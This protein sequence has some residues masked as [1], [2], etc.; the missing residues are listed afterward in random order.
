M[1]RFIKF[2]LILAAALAVIGVAG[3]GVGMAMG[4]RPGQFLNLAHYEGSIFRWLER[5]TDRLDAWSEDLEDSAEDWS[6][7]L[8]DNVEDWSDDVEDSVDQWVDDWEHDWE[9]AWEHG[10]GEHHGWDGASA[11]GQLQ[12]PSGDGLDTF[13]DSFSA[14]DTERLELDLN[15]AVVRIYAGEEGSDIHMSGRNGRDYFEVSQNNGTLKL[16]DSRTWEQQKRDQALELEL[17]LPPR[18]LDAV[19]LD[20]GASDV[21]IEELKADHV[22]IDVGA[23]LLAVER[24]DCAEAEVDA[25]VGSGTLRQLNAS[26]KAVLD[27]GAGELIVN[28]FE[29]KD[30]DLDCGVGTL[31]VTAAGKEADYNYRIDCGIGTIQVGSQSFSGLDRSQ[32]ID[33]QA[34]KTVSADCGIGMITLDFE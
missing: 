3:I 12:A 6:D 11:A 23:G 28:R 33:N 34:G 10:N 26:E 17:W 30:I 31:T 32:T 16:A 1:K 27:V 19:D 8:E 14:E 7:N 13:E 4:A 24:V 29:G 21:Q 20:V 15:F 18:M 9:D 22:R 2:C 25:G 5:R